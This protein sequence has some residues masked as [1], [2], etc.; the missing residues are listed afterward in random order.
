MSAWLEVQEALY[1]RWADAWGA[2]SPYCYADEGFDPPA[3]LWARFSVLSMPGGPGTLGP[4]G[5]RRFDRVGRIF[6]QLF[7]PPGGGVD[8]ISTAASRAQE[9]FEGCRFGPHDIRFAGVDIGPGS[10][11]EGGRWWAVTVEG[12]FDWEERK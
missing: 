2:T 10:E 5:G 1:A 3:A 11:I 8:V 6:A 7:V 12:R 9:I 4:R